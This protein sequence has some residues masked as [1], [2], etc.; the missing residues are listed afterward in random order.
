MRNK[1]FF[2]LFAFGIL[3]MFV[4]TLTVFCVT[5]HAKEVPKIGFLYPQTGIYSTLGPFVKDGGLM[6]IEDHGPLLGKTPRVFVKD[7]G[8]DIGKAVSAAKDLITR[9]GV[10]IIIGAIHTPTN[11]AVAE[12]CDEYKIPFL[13]PSG[14]STFMSGIAKVYPYPGGSV[15]P[16]VH[17][18]MFYTWLGSPQRAL[19]CVEVA[20]EYGLKWFWIGHDYEH[21]R[22]AKGMAEQVLIDTFGDKYKNVGESWPKQPEVDYT[23]D[24]SKAISA[25]ADVV[26]VCTPGKFVM[27]T[28]QAYAMGLM[29]AAHMHWSYTEHPA[30]L[31]APTESLGVTSTGDYSVEI[32][33]SPESTEF[34]EKVNKR[35]GYWPGWPMHSTY[36]GTRVFLLAVEK[37]RSLDSKKIM[38]AIQGIEDPEPITGKP[39][40]VRDCDHKS[41]QPLYLLQWAESGK[42]KPG[43]WKFVSK[44]PHPEKGLL[45]CEWKANYHKMEY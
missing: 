8:T 12:V 19:A 13:Y 15:K 25:R 38:R 32:P 14:G 18:Y 22:E 29:K 39:F 4:F 37:A 31:A 40:Y 21:G 36:Q 23:T 44:S 7:N 11:N 10:Q 35:Y 20:K 3:G 41:V 24:I 16:N 1:K 26:W 9:A 33:G 30:A 42:H 27:I 17:P 43:Y 34:A 5:S 45:P 2:R 6:A 28:K